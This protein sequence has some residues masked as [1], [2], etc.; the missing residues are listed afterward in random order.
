MNAITH[1]LERAC[2]IVWGWPMIVLL[3]GT[4]LFLTFRLKVP[5][6]RIGKAIKLSVTKDVDSAGDVSQFGALATSLAA[7]IGTGNIIGVATAIALGGPGALFWCFVAGLF[8]IATKYAEGVLAV[9]YRV[10]NVNGEMQGGPMYAL[11]RGLGMRWLAVLFCV[12]TALASFGIGNMVQSNAIS[13]SV[14]GLVGDAVPPMTVRVVV[15][16]LIATLTAI[17]IF[18]GVKGISRFCSAL[19]PPM[20]ALYVVGCVA[21]LVI[22]RQWLWPSLCTIC[23]DAFSLKAGTGG[24]AGVAIMTTLRFGV[25]RGLFSNESGL[26]SAPIVAAA[27]RSRNPVRQALVLSSGA[28][29]DTAVICTLTGLVVV[30][31][32]LAH[33]D[34]DPTSPLLTYAAFEKIPFV[35]TPLLTFGIIMFAFTTILGWSY[36]GERAI[37]YMFGRRIVLPYRIVWV[38]MTCVGSVLSLGV[39]W[40]FADLMNAMMALPNLVALVCLSGVV[41]RETKHYLWENRLDEPMK[42][43]ETAS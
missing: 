37:E 2:D 40:N 22:N 34:I 43:D 9:K 17:V 1:L 23:T 14:T 20:A 36:Y 32:L 15:G 5:Q 7:T 26:G 12:F 8:G 19:V 24:V 33:P 28:F 31:S 29:W 42:E 16:V 3:M 11:E 18:G 35:G 30:S 21:I 6:R 27:A 4:H 39:V 10:K 25:A 13:E 41:A 38:V